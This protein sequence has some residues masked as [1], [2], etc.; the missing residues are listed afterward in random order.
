MQELIQKWRKVKMD[1]IQYWSGCNYYIN[2]GTNEY[3]PLG[4]A[5]SMH[6][7]GGCE[8]IDICDIKKSEDVWEY[9]DEIGKEMTVKW[10]EMIIKLRS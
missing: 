5:T 2:R 1:I 7:C 10:N 8:N 4:T 3:E 6:D 9:T